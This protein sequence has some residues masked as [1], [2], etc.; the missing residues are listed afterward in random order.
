[1]R[2]RDSQGKEMGSLRRLGGELEQRGKS[3]L[4]RQAGVPGGQHST[5]EATEAEKNRSVWGTPSSGCLEHG[6]EEE[7][8]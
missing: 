3:F 8:G 4:V 6:A 2:T 1:M 5:H 7:A